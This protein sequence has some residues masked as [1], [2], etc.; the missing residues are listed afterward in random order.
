MVAPCRDSPVLVAAV[1]AQVDVAAVEADDAE[2]GR[3]VEAVL[4]DSGGTFSGH[5]RA[6]RTPKS[7]NYH[8]LG[9]FR[10]ALPHTGGFAK[11]RSAGCLRL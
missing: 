2:T 7:G 5:F 1:L 10:A 4:R 9:A 8:F 3:L 6:P 11:Q